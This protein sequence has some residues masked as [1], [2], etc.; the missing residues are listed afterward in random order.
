MAERNKLPRTTSLKRRA[1]IDLLLKTG[2][3]LSGDYFSLVWQKSSDF[4]FGVLISRKY[5]SAAERNRAKR[6]IREAV[7][8]NR[9]SLN[10][11]VSIAVL[12]KPN[13]GE[14]DFDVINAEISRIFKLI[15][16]RA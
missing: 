15:N 4:K 8:L 2:N 13:V 5:G 10:E 3:R 7:R 12:P 9:Q 11:S 6:L 14:P 1:D 16:D